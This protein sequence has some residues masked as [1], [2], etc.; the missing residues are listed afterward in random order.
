[1]SLIEALNWRYATKKMN[2]QAVPQE[3]VDQ[4]LEA[5]RLAP[6]S[7]GLQPFKV[8]VITDPEL[9]Q[10]LRPHS[11]DQSQIV[12]ASHVL[13]F[14]AWDNYTEERI[15]EAFNLMNSERGLPAEAT[16]D[17]VARLKSMYLPRE[18][19]VNFEHAAR[20]AYISFGTAIAEAA[21]LKVD[22]TPMEGFDNA[23][24]D[25][26]LNLAEQG[27][28]S[29]TVLPLGYRDTENDWLAGLKKV[30]QPKDNFVIEK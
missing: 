16:A 18:A 14:A 5:A 30:R 6:S 20:Q 1:M 2:G 25:E 26:I 8:I 13:V 4:I 22:A 17:Y 7:S 11:F 19:Q 28:K 24:Y 15:D 12:D 27:L 29:V 3:K 9:K 10:T 21:L 23:K